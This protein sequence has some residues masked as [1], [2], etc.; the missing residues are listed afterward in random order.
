MA[1]LVGDRLRGVRGAIAAIVA[2]CLPGAVIMIVT[3]MLYRHHR[4]RPA[5]TAMLHGVAAAAVGLIL[6]TTVQLGRKSLQHL[7]DLVFV[8]LT[9]AAINVFHQSVPRALFAVGAVAVLWYRPR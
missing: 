6:A 7:Y 3:G 9:V 4:D 2:V 8:A 5:V 1:V